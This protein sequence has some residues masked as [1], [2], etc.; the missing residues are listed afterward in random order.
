LEPNIN[1]GS[2][3]GN[4][5]WQFTIP[6]TLTTTSA[7][8]SNIQVAGGF[9]AST[10]NVQP[11]GQGPFTSSVGVSIVGSTSGTVY[12]STQTVTS[13][14]SNY[15]WSP[16]YS[17]TALTLTNSETYSLLISAGPTTLGGG[18]F[19]ALDGFTMSGNAVP[20]PRVSLLFGL[21][22]CV[23]IF[24]RGFRGSCRHH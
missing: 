12:S 20:E 15:L 1:T 4:N 17:P 16:S 24:R 8:I 3:S 19:M 14:T 2:G 10:G 13:T 21:G 5:V 18:T 23:L 6:F 9:F 7:T 22:A 11:N